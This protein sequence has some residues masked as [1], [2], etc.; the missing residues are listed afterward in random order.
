MKP[1]AAPNA[2]PQ[3][4]TNPLSQGGD[5]KEESPKVAFNCAPNPLKG[6]KHKRFLSFKSPLGDLGAQLKG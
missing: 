6:A 1:M 3:Q 2:F 5:C 4:M